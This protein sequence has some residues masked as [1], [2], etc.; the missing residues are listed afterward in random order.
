MALILT[1]KEPLPKMEKL[2][3]IMEGKNISLLLSGYI[4]ET[5]VTK[6]ILVKYKISLG[7]STAGK[8]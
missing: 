4:T 6:D 8:N 5:K 2:S 7:D 3:S 1:A